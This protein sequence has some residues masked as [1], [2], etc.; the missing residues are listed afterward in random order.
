MIKF[1]S[2]IK[3]EVEDKSEGTL[4]VELTAVGIY[5]KKKGTRTT[6]GPVNWGSVFYSGAKM[7]AI[8]DMKARG[9]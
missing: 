9:K 7:Q 8:S 1:T 2:S 3:R 6:Y 5:I 4:V